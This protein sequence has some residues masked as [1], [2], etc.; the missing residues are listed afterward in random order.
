MRNHLKRALSESE[1]Q[2]QVTDLADVL[3]L[4]WYHTHDSRRSPSGFPDLVVAG[5]GGLAFIELKSAKGKV[6]KEQREWIDALALV[7]DHVYVCYPS[8]LDALV[9]LFHR[10]AGRRIRQEEAH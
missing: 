1:F 4:K 3:H 6:S 10:L 9:N 8:D 2:Q 7:H 5:A